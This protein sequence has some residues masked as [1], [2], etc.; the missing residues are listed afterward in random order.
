MKVTDVLLESALHSLD[1]FPREYDEILEILPYDGHPST[2]IF[3]RRR[4]RS[5]IVIF[6]IT[7]IYY[8]RLLKFCCQTG[9]LSSCLQIRKAALAVAAPQQ[10]QREGASG[11]C[12]GQT[13][14]TEC[15]KRGGSLTIMKCVERYFLNLPTDQWQPLSATLPAQLV[16]TKAADI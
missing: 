5:Q 8:H 11:D 14:F 10:I 15:S 12:E 2:R 13:P 16:V 4:L 6:K 9:V 3:K 7:Q 1:T